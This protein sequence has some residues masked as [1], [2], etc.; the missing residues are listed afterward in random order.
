MKNL[1]KYGNMYLI[2]SPIP[3]TNSTPH[4]GHLLEGVF[5][6]TMRR[7]YSRVGNEQVFLT[8]GL[9]QHGLKIYE[10]ATAQNKNPK[11]FVD[12]LSV[13][14]KDLWKKYEVE[15]SE[16]VETSSVAHK[17]VSQAVWRKLA[18]KNLI[19]KK[20]YSG[21]YCVGCE[22][23]YAQSQS[24]AGKC[25]IHE[26][27]LTIMNEENYFF[28]L[29]GFKPVI[30]EYL[31]KTDIKPSYISKEY[32]NFIKDLQDISISREQKRLPWGIAVPEDNTQVMY[33][34]FEA[35]VN[36]LTAVVDPD[37]I[38][39][40]I[41]FPDSV[42]EFESEL[43]EDLKDKL[44]INLMYVSKEIAKFHIVIFIAILAGLGLQLPERVLAHG[45]INDNMGRKF[46]KSLNN[47]VTPEQMEEKYGVEGTRF[48][49][50]YGV[51]VDGDTSFDWQTMTDAYNAHLAN[52]IGNLLMR[53]TTLIEKFCG[54]EVDLDSIVKPI[55]SFEG[56]YK[57]LHELSPREALD[58]GLE[59]ARHGNEYLEQKAPWSLAKTDL[60]ATKVILTELAVLLRDLGV[61]LSVFMPVTG[62]SIIQS[63][64]AE[65]ITKATPLFQ[66]IDI[67]K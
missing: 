23:F 20:S 50:M 45:L 16:F 63:I 34:W 25:P 1:I 49:L 57:F 19:Y 22:D 52:N 58:I 24:I 54:G 9:D 61:V 6:D 35:L 28:R 38:E 55:Y 10:S 53:V 29:A 3:Y 44:P 62:D 5:V 18:S 64:T 48:L 26:T 67:D 31:D 21:L 42:E 32:T 41:E 30:A 14:Y 33:V 40:M 12:E 59:G 4:L 11:V 13:V 65:T 17:M 60:E 51:N 15:Y 27:E 36:Y 8:M 47:G 7:F 46:S 43:F 66:K 37:I 2:T 56:V 39:K